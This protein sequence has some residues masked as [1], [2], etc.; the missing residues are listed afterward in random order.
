MNQVLRFHVDSFE[1]TVDTDSY[2]V[3]VRE[4]PNPGGAQNACSDLPNWVFQS[5]HAIWLAE[6]NVS[7]YERATR[8]E[9]IK[10]R[11][12]HVTV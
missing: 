9:K 8:G 3:A 5:K 10:E 6:D 1:L 7:L 4:D 2:I 12:K 11:L